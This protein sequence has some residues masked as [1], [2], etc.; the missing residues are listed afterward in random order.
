[1]I[2]SL[3]FAAQHFGLTPPGVFTGALYGTDRM[4]GTIFVRVRIHSL[5]ARDL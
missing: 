4:D 1:M 5:W 3:A 2:R